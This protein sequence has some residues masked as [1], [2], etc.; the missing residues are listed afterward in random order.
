MP[1]K[2]NNEK[3]KSATL[4]ELAHIRLKALSKQR[5]IL[6]NRLLDDAVWQFLKREGIA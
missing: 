2:K 4:N 6:I 3:R 1:N 5:G